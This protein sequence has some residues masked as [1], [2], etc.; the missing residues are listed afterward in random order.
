MITRINSY[1][2]QTSFTAHGAQ[3]D[4][5]KKQK[6]IVLASAVAGTTPVL[7]ILAH[8]KGFSLN[9]S[10]IFKTPIK[11]WAIFKYKPVNESIQYHEKEIL[12][13]A[14]GSVAGGFIGGCLV[15]KKE[16]RKAKQ[17]EILSQMVGNIAVPVFLVGQGARLYSKYENRIENAV[18]QFN[19]NKISNGALKKVAGFTNKFMK[20]LPNAACTVAFLGV[21]IYV[22]NKVSNFINE[23]IYKKEVDREIRATDFA[24]HFDDLC[25]AISMMNKSSSVGSLLGRFIPLALLV[26]GYQTGIT[27]EDK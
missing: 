15:D 5:N 17:R 3:T 22:G 12:G 4:M 13:V 20:V 27:Q 14:A 2:N 25:M 7:A 21:G 23:K 8:K 1:N 18:P 10:K 24:P 6:S 19:L 16:N 26:P 11:D 9:P